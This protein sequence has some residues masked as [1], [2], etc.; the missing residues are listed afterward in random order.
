MDCFLNWVRERLMA[1]ISSLSVR[2]LYFV[3]L[4]MFH[5]VEFGDFVVS[6][7][8]SNRILSG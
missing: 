2:F 1:A 6:I 4:A 7:K 8:D 3:L 5:F